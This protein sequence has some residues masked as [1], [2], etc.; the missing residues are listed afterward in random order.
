M[1]LHTSRAQAATH[2][3]L[4]G[5]R[6]AL[7]LN[8][9]T[10]LVV[11]WFLLS[12]CGSGPPPTSFVES[13]AT[14]LGLI[15][16]QQG[17]G[18][19]ISGQWTQVTFDGVSSDPVASSSGFTGQLQNQQ[20]TITAA[21]TS[22]GTLQ[23]STL[24]LSAADATGHAGTQ[25]WYSATQTQYNEL[26]SA[27]TVYAHLRTALTFLAATVAYPPINSAAQSYDNSVQT[28][29]QYVSNL[30]VQENS[31]RTS[32]NPCGSTGLFDQL[33]PP[34]AS[35]FQ[36]T[37]YAT[38]QQAIL[39]TTIAQQLD[40]VRARWK[41]AQAVPFPSVPG[42]P[43]PWVIAPRDETQAERQGASLNSTLLA[44]LQYDYMKISALKRQ[45]QRIGLAVRQIKQSHGC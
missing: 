40:A 11:L 33:Y 9:G 6:A 1:G 45:A 16:W 13:S 14:T 43:L 12:D 39:H 41:E 2:C 18:S 5:Q 37:P 20:I 19:S 32:S 31:I 10:L 17:S 22:T 30:Q 42:L 24:Q 38:A 35:L 23:G 44:T 15:T 3:H 34:D 25:V 27:F 36:L 21:T 28:A 26:A 8:A 4:T 7:A 29:R